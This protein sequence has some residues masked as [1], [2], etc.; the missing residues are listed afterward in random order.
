MTPTAHTSL[1]GYHLA[2]QHS[3]ARY[4]QPGRQAGRKVRSAPAS[5]LLQSGTSLVGN[6]MPAHPATRKGSS[7]YL[8]P[9]RHTRTS[10]LCTSSSPCPPTRASP[11]G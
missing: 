6:R 1:T 4:L 5:R 2:R 7:S 8:L 3:G 9:G 10:S 11:L